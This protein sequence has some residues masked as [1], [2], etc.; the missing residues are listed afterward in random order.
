MTVFLCLIPNVVIKLLLTKRALARYV[1]QLVGVGDKVSVTLPCRIFLLHSLVF[2]VFSNRSL[3]H[4]RYIICQYVE[5]LV[6]NKWFSS[7][8]G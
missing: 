5:Y 6:E 1:L 7:Y 3:H 4:P 2:T 8:K